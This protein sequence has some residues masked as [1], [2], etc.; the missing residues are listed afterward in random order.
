MSY[1]RRHNRRFASPVAIAAEPEFNGQSSSVAGMC[2]CECCKRGTYPPG[3]SSRRTYDGDRFIVP[4]KVCRDCAR[5]LSESANA[6]R[7]GLAAYYGDNT[8]LPL[9]NGE[10]RSYIRKVESGKIPAPFR[11]TFNLPAAGGVPS[12]VKPSKFAGKPIAAAEH[13]P[14]CRCQDCAPVAAAD[15]LAAA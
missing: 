1:R 7:P 3:L 14:H 13:V 10:L 6:N 8:G 2:A 15:S 5:D 9:W 11:A 4:V 12:Y